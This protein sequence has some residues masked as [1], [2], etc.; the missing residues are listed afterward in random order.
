MRYSGENI[1]L[2]IKN[3]KLKLG[4]KKVKEILKSVNFNIK[5]S[6]IIAMTGSSGSGKSLTAYAILGLLDKGKFSCDGNIW[7]NDNGRKIDLLSLKENEYEQIRGVKISMVFQDPYSSFDPRIKCGNQLVEILKKKSDSSHNDIIIEAK[8]QFYRFGLNDRIFNSYPHQIS[9]GELQR[10]S[11]A[12]ALAPSPDLLITDEPVTNL[13]AISKK[14]ILDLIREINIRDGLAVLYISHDIDSIKYLSARDIIMIKDGKTKIVNDSY[15]TVKKLKL[16]Q[17]QDEIDYVIEDNPLL[18]LKNI[19]KKYKKYSILDVFSSSK[20]LVAL[21]NI[22]LTLNRGEIL[23]IVGE[24][25]SGKTTLA[26]ILMGL[27]KI[28]EGEYIFD[29][30]S[31][32]LP[33]KKD[34][35]NLRRHIQMVYQNPV[36]SLNPSISNK[37]LIH[38]PFEITNDRLSKKEELEKIE[39]V[40]NKLN[41]SFD[42]LERYPGQL[43][44]GEAQRFAIARVLLLNPEVIIFDEAVSSLDLQNQYNI[45]ENLMMLQKENQLSYIYISHDLKLTR[46]FCDKLI[47]MK[48]GKIIESGNNK[49]IFNN[50][51]EEYTKKLLNAGF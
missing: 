1:V 10:V 20:E 15:F 38:E 39:E 17:N 30:K 24:S 4:H 26:R 21:K 41:L 5:K 19:W 32:S 7:F 11:F 29:G 40:F 2:E 12:I 25:G 50:P 45:L 16:N 43:S 23:G 46:Q 28:D 49:E 14:E 47:I 35:K 18:E 3:L 31:Y 42:I 36:S 37:V 13:D 8:K 27:E 51:K 48:D 34:I 22:N 6:Q 33:N 44:G 9:G